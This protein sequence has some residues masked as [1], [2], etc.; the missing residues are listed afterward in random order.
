MS[1]NLFYIDPTYA[2]R[3]AAFG[4]CEVLATCQA[5]DGK[6]PSAAIPDFPPLASF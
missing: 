6:A 1:P 3:H 5:E 4:T 2:L